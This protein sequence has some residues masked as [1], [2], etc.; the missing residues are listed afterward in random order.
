M[1]TAALYYVS[2]Y[3]R[4]E[5]L[6]RHLEDDACVGYYPLFKEGCDPVS[7]TQA[8]CW[9]HS[10]REFFVFA[11]IAAN[12]KPNAAQISTIA[13]E[14]VKRIPAPHWCVATHVRG[15]VSVCPH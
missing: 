15:E 14:A 13:L 5:H 7:L 8:L 9:V 2:R 1:I 12:A 6:E 3:R 11:D 4:H 10:P